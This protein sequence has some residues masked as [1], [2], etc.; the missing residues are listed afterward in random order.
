MDKGERGGNECYVSEVRMSDSQELK[1]EENIRGRPTLAGQF[2]DGGTR[3]I[4]LTGSRLM[5]SYLL[6]SIQVRLKAAS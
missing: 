2:R 6:H 3:S 4:E 5:C 1:E